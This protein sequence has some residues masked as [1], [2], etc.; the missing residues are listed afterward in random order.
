MTVNAAE[1]EVGE[2]WMDGWMD[3]TN[4]KS[5]SW[6]TF[7]SEEMKESVGGSEGR[8]KEKELKTTIL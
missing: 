8:R 2:R 6:E 7:G 5:L 4:R 1:P 3:G